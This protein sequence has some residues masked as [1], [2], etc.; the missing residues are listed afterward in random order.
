VPDPHGVR[1]SPRSD[2]SALHA[3]RP[4]PR[5]LSVL[6]PRRAR[7]RS[8]AVG[9][10]AFVAVRRP[11]Q[12]PSSR[13]ATVPPCQQVRD[14]TLY[15]GVFSALRREGDDMGVLLKMVR[16]LRDGEAPDKAHQG[17]FAEL[18]ICAADLVQVT[19]LIWHERAELCSQICDA[20]HNQ[21]EVRHHLT[22]SGARVHDA[23]MLHIWHGMY[24]FGWCCSD[25]MLQNSWSVG[26]WPS[27]QAQYT[28]DVA[29][30]RRVG[31]ACHSS[32]L[33]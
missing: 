11:P 26:W 20:V 25:D 33:Q 17:F 2:I 30:Q 12:P 27:C 9:Q 8:C 21:C 18:Y 5:Q 24:R 6:S 16:V 31:P 10:T 32:H 7:C 28:Y 1:A 23:I 15:D 19:T 22:S 14:G 3:D 29:Q 13:G 4:C